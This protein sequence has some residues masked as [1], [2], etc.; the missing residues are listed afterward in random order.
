MAIS[1]KMNRVSNDGVIA[2]ILWLGESGECRKEA[3]KAGLIRTIS[4][5][6]ESRADHLAP[7]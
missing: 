5:L 3:Q 4:R 2:G 6:S 1:G 7:P